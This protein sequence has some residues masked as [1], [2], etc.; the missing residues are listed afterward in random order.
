MSRTCSVVDSIDCEVSAEGKFDDARKALDPVPAEI[1]YTNWEGKRTFRSILPLS[2]WYGTTDHHPNP[3]WFVRAFAFNR[4]EVRDF[5]MAG[6]H[7]WGPL[8]ADSAEG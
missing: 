1:D 2:L 7:R 4:G 5:A 8:T 6:I 3:Q